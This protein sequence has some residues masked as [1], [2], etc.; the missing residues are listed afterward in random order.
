MTLPP[1][2]SEYNIPKRK[3]YTKLPYIKIRSGYEIYK[4]CPL[5]DPRKFTQSEIFGLKVYHLATL[6]SSLVVTLPT[7]IIVNFT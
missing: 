1:G 4:V 7:Y 3:K 6:P 5:Q 2:L